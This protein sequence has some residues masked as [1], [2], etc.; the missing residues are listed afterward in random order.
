MTSL[1]F[2]LT[3]PAER[4][5]EEV[6]FEVKERYGL[7]IAERVYDDLLRRFAL[8]AEMSKMG[9]HRPEPWL[10]P[11][12]SPMPLLARSFLRFGPKRSLRAHSNHLSRSWA[13]RILLIV[14][15]G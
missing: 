10:A 5:L 9:R 13:M 7:L 1:R 3:A 11:Y 12:L 15:T 6:F 2:E 4:D 14:A 8:L